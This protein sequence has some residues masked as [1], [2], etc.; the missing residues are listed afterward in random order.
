MRVQLLAYLAAVLS[1]AR[2][3]VF[4]SQVYAQTSADPV[5]S[6]DA[7]PPEPVLSPDEPNT[8]PVREAN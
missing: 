6:P 4:A 7:V 2:T 5:P 3:F 8:R 1:S